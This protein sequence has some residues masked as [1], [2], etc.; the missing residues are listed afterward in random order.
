M[1]LLLH[2]GTGE[3]SFREFR[4]HE[5]PPYAILSHTWFAVQEGFE[6]TYEDLKDGSGKEKFGYKKIQ[7]CGG[8]TGTH[9]KGI[10]RHSSALPDRS[11]T[12]QARR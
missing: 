1:R 11:S 12:D 10:H 9:A 7:F 8:H 6:P 5:I 4:D 3:F 2:D